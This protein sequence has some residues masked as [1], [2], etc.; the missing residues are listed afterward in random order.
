[1]LFYFLLHWNISWIISFF[2]RNNTNVVV[3]KPAPIQAPI[4]G[5]L[6]HFT[7]IQLCIHFKWHMFEAME[8]WFSLLWP[9]LY[10]FYFL[11]SLI[12]FRNYSVIQIIFLKPFSLSY[13]LIEWICFANLLLIVCTPRQDL[14]KHESL[15]ITTYAKLIQHLYRSPKCLF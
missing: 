5:Y 6:N 12:K 1:L 15:S 9:L 3:S 10:R 11:V 4:K 14:P 13:T 2:S 8:S 7:I